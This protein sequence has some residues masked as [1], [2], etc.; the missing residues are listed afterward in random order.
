MQR[1]AQSCTVASP[2]AHALHDSNLFTFL[3]ASDLPPDPYFACFQPSCGCL[4]NPNLTL[5]LHTSNLCILP[6]T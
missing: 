2:A 4:P 6:T 3:A 1:T 5:A